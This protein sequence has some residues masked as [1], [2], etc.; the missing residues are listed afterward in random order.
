MGY[1]LQGQAELQNETLSQKNKEGEGTQDMPGSRRNTINSQDKEKRLKGHRAAIYAG[2]PFFR[3]RVS[4]RG[5]GWDYSHMPP[6]PA[7]FN[8][9]TNTFC[10]YLGF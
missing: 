3:V 1:I 2:L 4:L 10:T 7:K 5:S 6:H 8:Y 9:F